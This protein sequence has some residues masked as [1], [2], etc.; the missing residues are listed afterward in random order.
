MTYTPDDQAADVLRG[1]D[2]IRERTYVAQFDSAWLENADMQGRPIP[3]DHDWRRSVA[4]WRKRGLPID[5]LVAFVQQAMNDTSIRTRGVW[6]YVCGCA[7][8]RI[9]ELE[10]SP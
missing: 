3:R 4:Q 6:R 8:T 9:R 7:W 1:V 10:G 5:E 2:T